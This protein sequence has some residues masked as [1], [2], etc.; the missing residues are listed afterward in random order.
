MRPEIL[1][2]LFADVTALPGVGPKIAPLIAK[3][4]GPRVADVLFTLPA[5]LID[6]RARPK[7]ADA[8]FGQ[9]ATVEVTVDRHDPPR[10]RRQPYRVICSDETGFLTLVFFHPKEDYLRRALPEGTRRIVSGRIEEYGGVRQMTHPDHIVDP[11]KAGDMPLIEPV[12]PLTAGLSNTLMRK[13]VRAALA[14]A[15]VVPEWQ[16]AAWL[17]RRGWPGWREAL[18]AVHAPETPDALAPTRPERQRLAYDEL[19]ANQLALALIRRARIKSAGRPV[20]GDGRLRALA[21]KA[22]PFALT[23]D[24]RRALEEILADMAAPE[25]MVRLVQGDVGSGKTVV[26]LLAML[27]AVEA[28]AQAAMMAPTEILARQHLESCAPVCAAAGVAVD[29]LTGRDKGAAREEKLAR[30][31]SGEI[32]ILFG[33]HALFQESVAFRDLALVVVD[34]QHRFGVHQR[35]ALAQKGPRPDMLVMTAT[36]IPR[37]LALT[38]YGDMDASLIR[39][40]PPGRKPVLTRTIP[41]ERLQEVVAAVRRAADA[42]EQIYWVCPLVEE[43]D[44]LDLVAAEERHEALKP[45][46]GERVGLVH[47]R[48]SAAEKDAVMEAFYEGR[49]SVL[50]ATTVIEVG[51]NAPNATIMVVEH[52]ERFG[53]AQLHQLRGRVGRGDRRAV[54]LLLYQGPLGETA[55]ARLKILRE[56]DDGFRIAEEDLRL[57]G[58]GDLLGA[59]QSGFPQFRIADLAAH[60][61]LLAAAR[62]DA[63]LVVEKD[64]DLKSARGAALRVLLYLFSRDDAVRLLRAG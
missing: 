11:E 9:L 57:R 10:A 31:A 53:L 24:Q 19:L 1:N 46:L 13:A 3:A 58:A 37:T 12:Y 17:A 5:G 61:E 33:T 62:D 56:T 6:R 14:R 23:G 47:G 16:D 60:G 7:L 50:V 43:S 8:P 29:M 39:E 38:A 28:G 34:E 40:K 48:M 59:A 63:R 35:M 15:P 20:R 4:A 27:N 36:P 41:V 44:A 21:A 26:A 22:L 52:A 51:V 55:K 30:L 45:H 2:P 54:C 32:Q 42:G 49:L 64:P 18:R 25:R